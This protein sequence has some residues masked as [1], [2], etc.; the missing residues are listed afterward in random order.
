MNLSAISSNDLSRI[1]IVPQ[2][3]VNLFVTKNLSVLIMKQQAIATAPE[4]YHK[5]IQ[6]AGDNSIVDQIEY[7]G[8]ESY[9]EN[10]EQLVSVGDKVYA[11]GKWSIKQIIQHLID[12][13]RVYVYRA[14]RFLRKDK[15]ELPGFDHNAYGEIANVDHRTVED[16]L[17]EYQLVRMTSHLFFKTFR[18][19]NFY[20]VGLPM[21]RKF[22]F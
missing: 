22:Q 17:E 19:K 9:L 14:M 8:L 10:L 21:V 4:Y 16:L 5:Y 2:K 20:E 18:K 11:Q 1:V 12:T 3:S 15:T 6:L 13:E 7:H